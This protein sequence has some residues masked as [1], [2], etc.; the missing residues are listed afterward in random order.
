MNPTSAETKQGSFISKMIQSDE[1]LVQTNRVQQLPVQ[2]EQPA[3]D[4]RGVTL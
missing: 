3:S 4:L 1:N 2:I